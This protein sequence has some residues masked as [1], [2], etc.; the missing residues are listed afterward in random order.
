VPFPRLAGLRVA[1]AVACL[2]VVGSVLAQSPPALAA[3]AWI[4]VDV[5]S[6]VTLASHSASQRLDPASLTKLMTA[7]VVFT[8]LGERRT[9]L[10]ADVTVTA[11]ALSAPGRAGARMYIEPGRSVTVDQLL[12]GLLVASGNDAAI[13]LAEHAAGSTAAFVERMNSEARRLGMNSTRFANPTGFSDPQQYSTAEDLARLAQRVLSDFPQFAPLFAL[14]EFTYNSITQ[15]NRNRL[16]WSDGS[17]D[18]MKT[19]HTE[20]AGWSVVATASRTQGS[21]ETA[22]GRR[23]VAVVLG[24]T[25]DAARAQEALRLLNFGYAAF[26]TVRLYKQGDV[27]VRP[28]VWKGD[29]GSV[30]LGVERDIYVT[31]PASALRA[32]GQTGLQSTLERPDPL[33]APLRKGETVGRLKVTAGVEPVADVPVIALESV[34]EA[35]LVGRAYDAVRLWWRRRN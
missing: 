31:V 18:G 13:A 20:A 15:A 23:L 30:S 12:R 1:V 5:S 21:G 14:R 4:L 7:Y 33:I 35:G 10:D 28:E 11:D 32:L 29:R 22:F 8:A 3:R 17:V 6:G 34:G 9:R 19:G 26:D 16:L 24:A 2:L 25:S 27:L